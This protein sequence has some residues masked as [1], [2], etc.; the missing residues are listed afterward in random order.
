MKFFNWL[1][2]KEEDDSLNDLPS[3]DSDFTIEYYPITKRYYPKYKNYYLDTDYHTGIMEVKEPY[4]FSYCDYG[5]TE[6]EA[7]ALIARFKEQRLKENVIII[8]K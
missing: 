6:A 4:L 5:S 7:E 2:G 3:K 1:F 8:K